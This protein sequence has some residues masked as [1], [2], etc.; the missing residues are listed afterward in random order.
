MVSTEFSIM[1]KDFEEHVVRE[2]V[3]RDLWEVFGEYF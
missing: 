1:I 2:D 3:N